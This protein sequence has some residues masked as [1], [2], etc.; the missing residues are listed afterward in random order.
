MWY[1]KARRHDWKRLRKNCFAGQKF[2]SA[3]KSRVTKQRTYR[4]AEAL[5]HPKAAPPQ[6]RASPKPRHPKA[7]PPQS[8]YRMEFFRNV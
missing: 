4:S 5:R 3:A 1:D 8:R 7:A 6:S 2:T